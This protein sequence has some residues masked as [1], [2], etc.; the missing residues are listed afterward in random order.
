MRALL[1]ALLWVMATYPVPVAVG[2]CAAGLA[3]RAGG[4]GIKLVAIILG[5]VL[6]SV[7]RRTVRSLILRGSRHLHLH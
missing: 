1:T 5:I 3:L 4:K 2:V 7:W 6:F